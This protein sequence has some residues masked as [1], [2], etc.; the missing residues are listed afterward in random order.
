MM[1]N[2][3]QRYARKSLATSDSSLGKDFGRGLAV[4]GAA[5]LG[6]WFLAGLVP[7]VSLPMLLVLAVV[8][9][10]FLYVKNS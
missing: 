7:F 2:E 9:G 1:S 10:G 8:A 4:T 3:L 5:G 6:F